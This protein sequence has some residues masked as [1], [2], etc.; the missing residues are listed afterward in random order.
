VFSAM[1]ARR[2]D[3][4]VTRVNDVIGLHVGTV[5]VGTDSVTAAGARI[6]DGVVVLVDSPLAC[7]RL[8][9]SGF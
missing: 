4:S 5:D 2:A 1:A 8:C 7:I 3:C 9:Q 6:A